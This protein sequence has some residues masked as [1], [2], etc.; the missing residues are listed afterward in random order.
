MK[1]LRSLLII[2]M[3]VLVLTGCGAKSS[4]SSSSKKEDKKISARSWGKGMQ[5]KDREAHKGAICNKGHKY[6][7]FQ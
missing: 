7:Q 4:D 5:Q 2:L 3:A 6:D 1:K